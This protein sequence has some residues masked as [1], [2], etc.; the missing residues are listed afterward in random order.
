MKN[1]PC[2]K[3]LIR[4][5]HL[6]QNRCSRCQ[7][8]THLA[9]LVNNPWAR[10]MRYAS[11]RCAQKNHTSYKNYGGRGIKFLMTLDEVA[12]LWERDGA[13][14]MKKASLDRLDQNGHYEFSNCRFI[15]QSENSGRRRNANPLEPGGVCIRGHAIIR[16]T[17]YIRPDGERE[18]LF[19]ARERR[20]DYRRRKRALAALDAP[21]KE[22]P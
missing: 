17:I 14:K 19:C 6:R 11:E 5:N 12:R 2:G 1:C 4:K 7:Q 10:Y 9:Y 16:E 22:K 3:P 15:E 20:N 8:E 13:A 21:A 18:C